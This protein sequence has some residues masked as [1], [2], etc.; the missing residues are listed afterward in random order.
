M[1]Y[2]SKP[3]VMMITLYG[4]YKLSTKLLS[5]SATQLFIFEFWKFVRLHI[6][7]NNKRVSLTLSRTWQ[8][9]FMKAVL[10][11]FFQGYH[12]LP[13][14]NTSVL[15]NAREKLQH[16][17]LVEQ[18]DWKQ[19][20]TKYASNSNWLHWHCHG[21]R[22]LIWLHRYFWPATE[23]HQSVRIWNSDRVHHF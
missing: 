7:K 12:R 1:A 10:K 20:W 8:D 17:K 11:Y 6:K 3:C 16:E 18:N 5:Y 14:A 4:E 9:M 19:T 13:T 2:Q 22:R 23:A 15:L 21:R